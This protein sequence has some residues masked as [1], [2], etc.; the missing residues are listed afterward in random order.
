MNNY[1]YVYYDWLQD[2][3][4]NNNLD[5]PQEGFLKGNMF[6]DLYSQYKDYK[7][8]VF[9]FKTEQE[10]KLFELQTITFAMHE[11]NLY[12][13]THPDDQ[14]MVMLFEDYNRKKEKLCKEYEKEYGSI[15]IGGINNN[16]NNNQSF[17]WVNNNWPWEV[18]NV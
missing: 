11:L 15:T 1:N 13:D 10:R 16:N 9:Q 6:Q 18:R 14:G 8:T 12:L 3:K 5:N 7:P 4:R 2:N 17:E